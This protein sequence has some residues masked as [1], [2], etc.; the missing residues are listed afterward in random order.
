MSEPAEAAPSQRKSWLIA[1]P[2]LFVILVAIVWSAVW[3]Y[4]A[5]RAEREIDAWIKR[6]ARFGRVWNCAE[7]SLEGFPFRF[8]LKCR[9]PTLETH[10]GDP[11]LFTA[12]SAHAVADIWAPNHIVAEFQP[13]ARVT[14]RTTGDTYDARWSL[15]QMSGVGDLSGRPERFS[16]QVHDAV[17][18]DPAVKLGGQGVTP[19]V[20][21]QQ[22]QGQVPQVQPKSSSA[23]QPAA[24]DAP[25]PGL[26]SAKLFEFHVRRHPGKDGG[27]DGVDYAL[28]LQEAHSPLLNATGN[29]GPLDITLQGTVTAA[30]DL[31]P[32]PVEQRLKA[33]AAAGGIARLDRLVLT[34]PNVAATASGIFALD[35]QGRLNGKLDLGFAGFQEFIAGLARQGVI[36]DDLS[37]I[38]GAIALAGKK[39]TVDGRKGVGFALGFKDGVLKLGPVPVGIVPPLF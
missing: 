31:R 23:P 35:T 13:P 36:P 20:P 10:G 15:L 21:E 5:N 1:L 19:P 9:E 17:L 3:V 27:L 12:A 30:A 11:F 16:L 37:P 33:W 32:M 14:D 28:G 7:R 29:P 24:P 6:E 22:A 38:V 18:D 25:P 26:V 39:T 8:E 34:T 2:L 4:A